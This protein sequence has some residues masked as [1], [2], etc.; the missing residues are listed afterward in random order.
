MCLQGARRIVAEWPELDE[1]Q[2]RFTEEVESGLIGVNVEK[3]GEGVKVEVGRT[4][5]SNVGDVRGIEEEEMREA[6]AASVEGGEEREEME[7]RKEVKEEERMMSKA[8]L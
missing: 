1:E 5:D 3:Y 2:K 7:Q 4:V 8:E 6:V